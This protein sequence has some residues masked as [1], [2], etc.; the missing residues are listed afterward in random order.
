MRHVRKFADAGSMAMYV[1]VLAPNKSGRLDD[2]LQARIVEI[3][4]AGRPTLICFNQMGRYLDWWRNAT[5]ADAACAAIRK[6]IMD[7]AL[8]CRSLTVF[9]TD[10]TE[11]DNQCEE[12]RLR[13][14]KSA[15]HV[16]VFQPQH[17]AE[18]HVCVV[19][20]VLAQHWQQVNH[21]DNYVAALATS[22]P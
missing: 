17:S 21:D 9:L 10:F 6:T 3:A 13:N 15:E 18:Q 7:R 22:S 4:A 5:Q 19:T 2:A 12:M 11:Y 14:I 20:V 1:I 16:S 8:T